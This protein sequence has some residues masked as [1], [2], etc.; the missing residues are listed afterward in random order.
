MERERNREAF[1]WQIAV[2]NRMSDIYVR[3]I[4]RRFFPIVEAVIRRAELAHGENVLDLGTGTGA[5]TARAAPIVG[6][7]GQVVGVDISPEMLNLARERMAVQGLTN[8][9]LLEGSGE[10]IPADDH[11]FDV[12]LCSLS[13]MYVIDRAAAAREIARVL[14]PDGRLVAAVW[15]GRDECDVVLF[16]ETAGLF[17]GPPPVSEVGPGALADPSEFREQLADAGIKT[18]VEREILGFDFSDFH[19]AWQALAGVTAAQLPLDQQHQ[20][21]QVVMEAMYP[22]GDAPRHF[23]NLT[24]F[25]MGRM[26][27]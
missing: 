18:F 23:R 11:A 25:I 17:A 26:Q 9:V 14:R 13:L 19:S 2:W 4:D 15:G 27:R 8:V 24:Q 20:A 7:R 22:S 10:N 16:Q 5:V 6:A 12:V 1:E 3:E 21:Q